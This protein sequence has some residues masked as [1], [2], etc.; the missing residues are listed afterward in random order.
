MDKSLPKRI[1]LAGLG[2][3]SRGEK[4]GEEWLAELMEE[5]EVFEQ[6]KKSDI[7]QSLL[8]MTDKLRNSQNNVKQR[9]GNMEHTFEHKVSKTLNKIGLI[10]RE[11]LNSLEQRLANLEQTFK[12]SE[13]NSDIDSDTQRK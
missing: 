7:E 3:I 12:D 5:G 6:E 2:A 9:L 13:I 10:S 8:N 11:E 1:W 4:E